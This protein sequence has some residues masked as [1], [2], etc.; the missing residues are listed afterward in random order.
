MPRIAVIGSNGQLGTDI[1]KTLNQDTRYEVI[2]LQHKHIEITD[3]T[4][5]KEV[6]TS[7]KPDVVINTAAF[8]NVP[9]CEK[10][11]EKA[12]QTNAIGALHIA[13]TCARLNCWNIY[14]STDYVFDGKKQSPYSEDDPPS[15]LNV[16][17]T[18]KLAGE[19]HTLNYSQSRGIVIRVSA[20]YGEVPSRVKGTNFVYTMLKLAREKK[21]IQVVNDEWTSPTW[22]LSIAKQIKLLLDKHALSEG[23]YH[24]AAHGEC[25]WYEF[26]LA[27]F[28]LAGMADVKVQP[29]S[30]KDFPSEVIRPQYSVLENK[31][32][33]SLNLDIMQSWEEDIASFIYT[34]TGKLKIK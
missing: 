22:T 1:V 14:I 23:I 17:G 29:V 2:E 4:S 15:P 27:I 24:C 33:K 18:S 21:T 8:H 32:L 19:M 10:Q 13:R 11:A 7:C 31:K 25:S 16:Y 3:E 9:L 20:I 12:Y 28:R 26:A 30:R 5:V 34:I 6:L